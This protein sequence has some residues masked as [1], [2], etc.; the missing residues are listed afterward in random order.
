MGSNISGAAA[1][2]FVSSAVELLLGEEVFELLSDEAFQTGWDTLYQA[3]PWATVFQSRA[4]V[5]TWYRIFQNEYLPVLLKAGPPDQPTGLLTLAAPLHS[6][7][8][9]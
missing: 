8:S 5:T 4:F 2:P 9:G 6:K 3:C 1:E 7:K